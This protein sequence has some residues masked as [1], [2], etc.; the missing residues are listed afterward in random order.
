MVLAVTA[1]LEFTFTVTV[2]DLVQ[3]RLLV[4]V[5]V[6]VLVVVGLAATVEVPIDDNAVEGF[7][8]YVAAPLA[9]N[10]V[11]LPLQM[12]VPPLTATFGSGLT[13][14]AAVALPTQPLASVAA[15]V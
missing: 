1:G 12:V 11:V 4:P 14:N 15:T 9:D 6:Y 7:H 5:T 10:V 3:P 8:R 2:A 13:V